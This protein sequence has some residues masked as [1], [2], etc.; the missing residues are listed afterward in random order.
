MN[1]PSEK[2]IRSRNCR[3]A[4]AGLKRLIAD[5]KGALAV[6]VAISAP[7][8]I[9]GL[10]LGGEVSYWYFTQRKLQNGSDVAAYAAAVSIVADR[11]EAGMNSAALSAAKRTGFDES[12]GTIT[13]N[14]PPATGA[15]AGD[16][17]AVEVILRESLPRMLTSIFESGNVPIS[18]RA[19]ARHDTPSN[20]CIL[21]LHPT[22]ENAVDFPGG[23]NTNLKACSVHA[24]SVAESAVRIQ[25]SAQLRTPCVSTPGTVQTTDGLTQDNCRKPIDH[26]NVVEDPYADLDPPSVTGPCAP[27]NSFG[28]PPTATY[29]INAE[30]RFCGGLA[31][32]R[33]ITM[34]PG[35]YVVD[36]G[37]FQINS[38]AVVNGTGVTVYLTNGAVAQI[39]GGAEVDLTAPTSGPYAGMLL[40]VD[41]DNGYDVHEMNGGANQYFTGV[42]YAPEGHV[43]FSGNNETSSDKCIQ[44]VAQ[45]ITMIGTSALGADCTGTGVAYIEVEPIISIVE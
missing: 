31:L 17:K 26:A 45:T 19:V 3:K 11:G 8:F 30:Y 13:V 25:G 22:A 23:G 34:E 9:G 5:Q 18:G 42:V 28:G 12:I 14:T 41:P 21:G 44:I 38:Q 2:K 32:Q 36:G 7:V 4:A 27:T 1:N 20:A 16:P 10:G 24:N 39:N 43:S 35:T 15:F 29:T 6:L 40:W 37:V 33:N